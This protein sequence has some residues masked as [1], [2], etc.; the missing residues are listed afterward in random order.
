MGK[1]YRVQIELGK[2]EEAL[3]IPRGDFYQ[4]TAGE[5][6][7][8]VDPT[9]TKAV[10]TPITIGRQNP[11]QYEIIEGLQPGDRVITSGYDR[12]GD[13]EMIVLK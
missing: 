10:R 9:G 12:L 1:S 6:I 11:S 3:V 4:A 2:A 8:R 7:F 5:W 13:V